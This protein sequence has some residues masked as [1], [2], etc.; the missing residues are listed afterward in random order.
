MLRRCMHNGLAAAC[1]I[2]G[3]LAAGLPTRVAAEPV[4]RE[5]RTVVVAGVEEVWQL[6]W[7]AQP[8]PVCGPEDISNA[9]TCP[10][11]GV[12]YGEHGKLSLVRRRADKEVERM[13]LRPLFGLDPF[14]APGD[15]GDSAY[16]QRWPLKDDD[17]ER[18][19][20]EPNLVAEIKQ[21]P[22]PTIMTFADYDR[23][24]RATEFLL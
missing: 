21:R 8:A 20:R 12:A 11:A 17:V 15:V 4:V 6:V 23:D 14:D 7:D 2:S 5:Q 16:L 18:E 3:M 9:T 24:G 22:A 1:L 19:K 10:C 13:D